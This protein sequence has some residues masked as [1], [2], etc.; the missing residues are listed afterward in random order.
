V[1]GLLL[2]RGGDHK[3]GT[4]PEDFY[5][6]HGVRGQDHQAS[7]DAGWVRQSARSLAE[8]LSLERILS[9]QPYIV[10]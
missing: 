7:E 6:A 9:D 8:A 4:K 2:T 5:D 10:C 3:D 1:I